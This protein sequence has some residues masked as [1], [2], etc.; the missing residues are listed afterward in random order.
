MVGDSKRRELA[1][2]A[3]EAVAKMGGA[4]TAALLLAGAAVF[5]G[6]A[7]LVLALRTRRAVAA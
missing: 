6:L 1:E 3:R 2:A 7:V 4:V 5:L